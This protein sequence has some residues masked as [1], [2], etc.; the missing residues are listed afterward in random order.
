MSKKTIQC[1]LIASE[2][3]RQ[4]LWHLMA[5]KNTPLINE[6]MQ[7]IAQDS[8]F[9]EWHQLGKISL[10]MVRERCQP[11]RQDP[12][13]AGQP[14]RFY[15]SA[16]ALVH[17]IYQSWFALQKSLRNQISGQTRW[18]AI[19]QSDEELTAATHSDLETLRAKAREIITQIEAE[20]AKIEA[21]GAQSSQPKTQKSRQKKRTKKSQPKKTSSFSELFKQYDETEDA[22]VRCAIAYLLKN[23][24]KLSDQPE[25]SQQFTKRRRKAEI[26][27][28]RL[29]NQFQRT[30]LPK[31][32]NL[33]WQNW[34]STLEEAAACVPNGDDQAADWQASLLTKPAILPFPVS[35]ETNE[36]LKWFV[37]SV[38]KIK[39]NIWLREVLLSKASHKQK[40]KLIKIMFLTAIFS[41]KKRLC[42]QFNG[43]SEHSFTIYCDRRQ[44]RWFKR[45]L[46]DQQVKEFSSDQPSTSL[47]TLRS[48]RISW[49]EGKGKGDP[50]NVHHL[51]LSCCID[52]RFWTIEGTEQVR[53]EKAI[54]CAKA[55]ARS[56]N[57]GKLNKKR[58]VPAQTTLERLD[59]PYP[60]PSC[61]LYQGQPA[62]LAGVSYGLN[63]PAT[64]AIVDIQ[65]G[66]AIIYRSI[67]QLLGEHYKLL[68]RLRLGQHRNAH[69]RR[70][71]PCKNASSHARESN[72]G[73]QIDCLIARA[74]VGIAQEYQ[75]SGIVLPD[76]GDIREIIQSEVQAKAEQKIPGCVKQQ[77]QYAFRYRGSVHRWSYARLSQNIHSQASQSGIAIETAKQPVAGT[78]QE[79]AKNLAISAYQARVLIS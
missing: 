75:A 40:L 44:I 15:T 30:R 23:G 28:E 50:W 59:V 77:R 47:F 14:G 5:D 63:K 4:Y 1:R 19:L 55:I 52:T 60:R 46:E 10:Q 71:N 48:G 67:R 45:F 2:A 76:L 22:L 49:Q 16:I 26:R 6:L 33:S 13:F 61:P 21:E 31:G 57:K 74:I 62:I 8:Q 36:D 9:E 58:K 43:F 65:T 11:L 7:Q 69:R 20:I 18:L 3:T 38:D 41:G 64:L 73:K 27:L 32:R 53:Q 17:R 25:D 51:V 37:R 39:P 72:L 54:E 42:V 78:P 79:K 34:L 70:N 66:K 35:Y 12:R 29:L 56:K 68:N 24:G